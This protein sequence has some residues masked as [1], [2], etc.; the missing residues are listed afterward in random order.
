[1]A[2]QNMDI[3]EDEALLFYRLQTLFHHSLM[4]YES[5]QEAHYYRY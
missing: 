1:M 5:K 2:N 4:M 3:Q